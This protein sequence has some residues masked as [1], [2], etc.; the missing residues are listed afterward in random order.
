MVKHSETSSK[1]R[2]AP[3]ELALS[4]ITA[5]WGL[6]FVLVERTVRVLPPVSFVAWS[7]LPAAAVA[8]GVFRRGLRRLPLRGWAAGGVMGVFLT[9]GY[10]CLS[11]GLQ[12]TTASHAGFVNGL[13]VVLTPILGVLL[14]RQRAG[15]LLWSASAVS[16][17]GLWLLSGASSHPSTGDLVVLAGAFAFAFQILATDRAVR[18]YDA[19]ALLAVQVAVCGIVATGVA[20]ATGQ[21]RMPPDGLVWTTL[22]IEALVAIDLGFFVQTWAQRTAAP[23]RTAI[24]MSSEPVFAGV[25]A[26]L[27]RGE[28]LSSLGWLGAG[29]IVGAIVAVQLAGRR[30]TVPDD[31]ADRCEADVEPLLELG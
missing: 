23:A 21:S 4:G 30:R 19:G 17:A 1:S 28:A 27:L 11:F 26:Y 25:F 31:V 24:I 3:A 22:T 20:V 14:M 15:W 7:F 18:R 2:P 5:V 16:L 9:T 13:F 29:L 8:A 12:R 6:T 10:L